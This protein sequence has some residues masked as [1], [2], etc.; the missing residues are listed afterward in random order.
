MSEFPHSEQL[1]NRQRT[2]AE[3]VSTIIHALTDRHYIPRT[4]VEPILEPNNSQSFQ[5]DIPDTREGFDAQGNFHR[6]IVERTDV[7][8]LNR[9]DSMGD[10]ITDL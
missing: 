8:Q 4:T 9:W 2:N 3:R 6:P 1:N 10:Y 7:A 5:H